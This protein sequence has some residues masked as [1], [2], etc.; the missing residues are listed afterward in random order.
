MRL[1]VLFALALGGVAVFA[2]AADAGLIFGRR[3]R[4]NNACCATT[5][6]AYGGSGGVGYGGYAPAAPCCGGAVGQ[7]GYNPGYAPAPP[8][9]GG[10]APGPMLIPAPGQPTVLP[11]GGYLPG[12]AIPAPM[13]NPIPR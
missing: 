13:P 5:G 7:A 11:T 8:C 9:C 12:S 2:D 3:N 4:G 6:V 1:F 10:G